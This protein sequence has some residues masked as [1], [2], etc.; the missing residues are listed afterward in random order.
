MEQLV[1]RRAH[2]PKVVGSSPAAATMT[3]KSKSLLNFQKT[4][5]MPIPM[6]TY[7][8]QRAKEYE[9]VYDK[10]ERQADL[11]HLKQLLEKAFPAQNILELACGTGYWT[12]ILAQSAKSIQAIDYSVSVMEVARSKDYGNCQIQFSEQDF[13]SFDSTSIYDGLFGGFIYSHI[14]KQ[15][16]EEWKNLIL[17]WVKP[18][19]SI[20]FLDNKF[21]EGSNTPINRTDEDGNT[22]QLRSL[23]NGN[24]YEVLKNFS[25]EAEFKKIWEPNLQNIQWIELD[26]YW[27]AVLSC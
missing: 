16:L 13:W 9:S 23:K 8:S 7:Y 2:N 4:F 11:Q 20:I 1:A 25:T 26:Y 3:L 27:L 14:D 24:Q 12:S 21:V 5:F 19:G 15:R 17:S 10:P 6:K 22:F 18:R